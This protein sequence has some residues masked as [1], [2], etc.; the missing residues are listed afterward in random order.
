[1]FSP[2][3]SAEV[4]KQQRLFSGVKQGMRDLN[5]EFALLFP[6]KMLILCN[7][8][9]HFFNSPSLVE[10]FIRKI[11][12]RLSQNDAQAEHGLSIR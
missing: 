7:G 8:K 6:A 10:D 2:D 4:Q 1:M 12:E 5:I 9:Q 3:L 11:K